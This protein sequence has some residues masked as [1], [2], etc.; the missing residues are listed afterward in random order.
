MLIYII[1]QKCMQKKI[2]NEFF[3]L[4]SSDFVILPQ[5]LLYI[6]SFTT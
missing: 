2:K 1:E 5:N 6:I 4:L 3:R